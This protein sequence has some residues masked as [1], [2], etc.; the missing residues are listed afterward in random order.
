MLNTQ[1]SVT[2]AA[3]KD[4]KDQTPRIINYTRIY[5]E[6]GADDKTEELTKKA[7]DSKLKNA[8]GSIWTGTTPVGGY[9]KMPYSELVKSAVEHLRSEI[10][11]AKDESDEDFTNRAD[12]EAWLNLLSNASRGYDSNVRN[13]IQAKNRPKEILSEDKAKEKAIKLFIAMGNDEATAKT[14]YDMLMAGKQ[15]EQQ[16]SEA[17]TA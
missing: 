15:K 3:P 10:E 1:D 2:I 5:F 8:D 11:K 4:A 13:N 9:S 6:Y 17:V 16:P 14:M 7:G 12:T